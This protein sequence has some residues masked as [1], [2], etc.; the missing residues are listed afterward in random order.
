MQVLVASYCVHDE[1]LG[2]ELDLE[3]GIE[4]ST[5]VFALPVVGDFVYPVLMKFLAVERPR[6][7][8]RIASFVTVVVTCCKIE[9]PVFGS[10]A[11]KV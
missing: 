9:F 3:A 2:L 11:H 7:I 8:I 6:I 1:I 4:Q 10:Q 5:A